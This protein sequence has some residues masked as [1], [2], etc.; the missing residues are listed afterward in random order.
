MHEVRMPKLTHD[1]Q[2]GTLVAWA[3]K[4]G[5]FMRRGAH[6]FDVETDKAMVEVEAEADGVLAGMC[7]A[8]G[9]E[10]PVGA[11]MAYLLA[12]SEDLPATQQPM[13]AEAS[14][15]KA[16]PPRRLMP[17]SPVEILL[18]P[19]AEGRIVASPIARHLAAEYHVDLAVLQGSGPRGRILERDVLAV[20]STA[21]TKPASVPMSTRDEADYDI[22]QLTPVRHHTA[23]R[24]TASWA[25]T[26]QFVLEANVDMTEALRWREHAEVEAS[27]TAL[28]VCA[29]AAALRAHPEV[30]AAFVDGELRV[31]RRINIGVAAATPSGLM[32]PV[33][34]DADR[35]SLRAIAARLEA[36][37]AAAAEARF[38]PSELVGGTFTISNL[39]PL[40]IDAFTAVVNPPQAAIL[41]VGQI[42]S[43]PIGRNGA[44]E[45]RPLMCLRLS[46]DHRVLDGA[47]A[48][49]FLS[50]V[51]AILENPYRLI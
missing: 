35:L 20:M 32:V 19:H 10:V 2:L 37:R 42:I 34:T 12:P 17:R 43:T 27:I 48:A 41:A 28:L 40:G 51:R 13:A 11:V 1:M 46:V 25:V 4:E 39:G 23:E 50:E 44:I 18:D 31:Y 14:A 49:P 8:P 22:V 16:P 29:V 7:V 45:L 30:N 9:S 24:L 47:Q 21:S 36:I 15:P 5:E 26:P 6:L 33:I 3:A 38:A